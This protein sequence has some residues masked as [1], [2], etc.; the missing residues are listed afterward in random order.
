MI[1]EKTQG[2]TT[3]LSKIETKQNVKKRKKAE[4]I[5]TQRNTT[6]QNTVICNSSRN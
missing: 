4:Q 3:K 2:K 5:K 6:Q 1:H